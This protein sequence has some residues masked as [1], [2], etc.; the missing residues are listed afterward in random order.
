MKYRLLGTTGVRVSEFALGTMMFGEDGNTDE[1][2]C[3]AIV[4]SALDAGINLIDTADTYSHGQSEEMVGKALAGCRDEVVLSSKV[5]LKAGEGP[6]Q[7][8]ASRLWIMREVEAS[9]RRLKTDHIDIY[10]IHRPDLDADLE[11]TLGALEDLIRSGKVRYAGSSLF[12]AWYQVEAQWKS[13]VGQRCR[14]VNETGPYS[15]FTRWVE[16]DLLPALQRYHLGFTAW[17]PLNGGWLTGKYRPDGGTP[18]NSRATLV[19][20]QWG[21][22][23]PILRQRFDFSRPGNQAKL[24]LVEQLA[25]IAKQAG[26]TL[27]HMAI[28][29]PLAHP[30]V[31]S[32]NLGVRT[33]DQFKELRA[34]F[35]V[36]LEADVL[37]AID[38]VVPPGELV[39]EADRGWIM[40]W[41]SA[42]ARRLPISARCVG[43]GA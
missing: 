43:Q 39:S 7:K 38:G 35:G 19:Q 31:T 23:Y 6:N 20:G 30:A 12:P 42:S 41:M 8:G 40:P 11:E 15:I 4:R 18:Q 24:L 1:K 17:S 27:A 9:L 25:Q 10:H 34:G 14:F 16:R 21:E 2:E 13:R 37:D 28:S 3:A 22:H 36:T 5:S 32:V 29:F 33:L 26:M